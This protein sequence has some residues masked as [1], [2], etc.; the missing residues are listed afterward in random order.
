[1]RDVKTDIERRMRTKVRGKEPNDSFAVVTAHSSARRAG[2]GLGRCIKI[3]LHAF[4]S[5]AIPRLAEASIYPT[6]LASRSFSA[7]AVRLQLHT[8]CFRRNA[9]GHD[10]PGAIRVRWDE[11]LQCRCRHRADREIF[12][13]LRHDHNRI[14][15]TVRQLSEALGHVASKI[16]DRGNSTLLPYALEGTE[17]TVAT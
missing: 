6:R 15:P 12:E 7:N 16:A 5:M 10:L 17:R 11:R 9:I 14:V 3:R 1:M 2:N 8:H 13:A 4:S